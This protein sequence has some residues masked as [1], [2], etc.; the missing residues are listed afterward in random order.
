[1]KTD[2]R[3]KGI[4]YLTLLLTAAAFTAGCGVFAC[5]NDC[6]SQP[7]VLPPGHTALALTPVQTSTRW[8]TLEWKNDSTAVSRAYVLLRNNKDTVYNATATTDTII[9]KD[10][11]LTPSTTYNYTLYRI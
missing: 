11:L 9:V 2:M 7:P 3:G 10:S 5:K 1:M 6:P 4:R 8:V